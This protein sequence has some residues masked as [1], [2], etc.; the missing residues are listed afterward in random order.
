MPEDTVQ[1][2]AELEADLE[3]LKAAILP[4]ATKRAAAYWTVKHLASLAEAHRSDSET[5]DE[6][7]IAEKSDSDGV[8]YDYDRAT[9]L[10]GQRAQAHQQL[11]EALE[12]I[13]GKLSAVQGVMREH[14]YKFE[15]FPRNMKEAPPVGDGERWEAFAF[16]LYSD[17][18]EAAS[19]AQHWLDESGAAL[20][21][22]ETQP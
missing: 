18:A 9:A 14:G 15:R 11:R 2:I 8:S 10:R 7:E 4:D 19:V 3:T 5:L 13:A 6:C 12:P 17:L 1:R 21:S 16:H 20:S 22:G